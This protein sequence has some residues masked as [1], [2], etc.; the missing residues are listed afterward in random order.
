MNESVGCVGC[1][2]ML[3]LS[4]WITW[5]LMNSSGEADWA[6]HQYSCYPILRQ[7][8]QAGAHTSH[9]SFILTLHGRVWPLLLTAISSCNTWWILIN[10]LHSSSPDCNTPVSDMRETC[11]YGS[12][13]ARWRVIVREAGQAYAYTKQSSAQPRPLFE[14]LSR[15]WLSDAGRGVLAA[16]TP[17]QFQM[18]N[19]NAVLLSAYN[20][21]LSLLAV[22][23]LVTKCIQ[24]CFASTDFCSPMAKMAISR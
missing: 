11:S 13:A 15:P 14:T 23:S 16:K 18:Q 10:S 5:I 24:R 22:S 12:I 21:D 19:A 8:Q 17:R 2:L 6:V 20:L 1:S 3:L 7:Q 9:G 4:G